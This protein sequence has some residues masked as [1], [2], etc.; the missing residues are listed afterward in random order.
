PDRAQ[1]T[2]ALLEAA[3]L[4]AGQL[5]KPSEREIAALLERI[6][7]FRASAGARAELSLHHLCFYRQL[8]SFGNVEAVPCD[9]EPAFQAGIDGRPGECRKI[10]GGVRHFR[11]RANGDHFETFLGGTLT[12]EDD[13][14]KVSETD[15]PAR[16]DYCSSRRQDCYLTF[17][18][19]VPP[20]TP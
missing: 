6:D 12:L 9:P 14:G 20:H 3:L 17:R 2:L 19:H 16:V 18:F 4:E 1:E 13:H 7:D 10:Y 15:F 8:A 11:S 5:K